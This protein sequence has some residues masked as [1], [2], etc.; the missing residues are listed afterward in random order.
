MK[1][2]AAVLINIIFLSAVLQAQDFDS[3]FTDFSASPSTVLIHGSLLFDGRYYID[4]EEPAS[5]V[6]VYT[7]ELNLDFS[8]KASASEV[9]ASLKYSGAGPSASYEDVLNEAWLR[10]FY[11]RHYLEAGFVKKV[12]GK[13]DEMKVLD[14]LNPLDYT[15][16]INR[17]RL[18]RKLAE[19]MISANIAIGDGGLLELVYIP[20][21]TPDVHPIDGLW[22]ASSAQSLLD[23]MTAHGA[24]SIIYPDTARIDFSQ[25]AARLTGSLGGFD[26]GLMYYYGVFKEPTVRFNNI[27][28]AA[29]TIAFLDYTRMHAVGTEAAAVLFTLNLRG[30]A[31]VYLSEDTDGGDPYKRNSK[32]VYSAGFDRDL[33]AG[34]SLLFEMQG[35]VILNN[36]NIA[37][38]LDADYDPD[39]DYTSNIFMVRVKSSYAYDKIRPELVFAWNLEKQ[40]WILRPGIEFTLKDDVLMRLAAAFFEGPSGGSFGQFGGND[41]FQLTLKYKF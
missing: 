27:I 21:F 31:A 16:F 2:T 25:A 39:G 14:L 36:D 28:P 22:V 4:A 19:S 23:F 29:S 6:P 12:W 32:V 5:S 7:P 10:V 34:L 40:D 26:L 18:E 41:F 9:F 37:N 24:S 38:Q 15:D 13:A 3:F 1:K 17:A 35:S 20:V 33:F 11:G 8:Y 30:E